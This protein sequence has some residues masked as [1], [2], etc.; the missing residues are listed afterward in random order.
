MN[1]PQVLYEG[2]TDEAIAVVRARYDGAK[3]SPFNEAECGNHYARAMA[4]WACIGA[5]TGQMYDANTGNL[6]FKP[7]A[8]RRS[9]RDFWATGDGWGTAVTTGDGDISIVVGGGT[10][11][12]G[13]KWLRAGDSATVPSPP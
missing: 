10:V 2:R 13:D 9:R 3:R 1:A 8:E 6:R 7:L 12:I 11:R 4:S 5:W